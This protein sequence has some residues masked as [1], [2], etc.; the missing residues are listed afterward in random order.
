MIALIMKFVHMETV[1]MHVSRKNVALLQNVMPDFTL[2]HACALKII[3]AI[4]ILH[5]TQVRSQNLDMNTF[6]YFILGYNSLVLPTTPSPVIAGCDNNN[7]CPDHA[8]CRNKLCINP[9][10]F[11]DPCSPTAF[12]KV[13]NHE[14]VCTCPDGYIGDPTISCTLRRFKLIKQDYKR[15]D[16]K[17]IKFQHLALNVQLIQ[18]V[19]T[20]LHVLEKNVKILASRARV[21]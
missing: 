13:F 8:A 20:I 14:P 16:I 21:E 4:Q 6:H 18:N 11:D 7:D 2:L 12:C 15:V 19:Q 9:C 3:L 5:A 1:N 10:A 17:T